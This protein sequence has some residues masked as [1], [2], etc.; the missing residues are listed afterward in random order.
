MPLKI[1]SIRRAFST[2]MATTVVVIALSASALG[3][4]LLSP[5]GSEFASVSDSGITGNGDSD[6]SSISD[7]GRFV[8]FTS[9]ATNFAGFPGKSTQIYRRDR[10][11]HT[12]SLVSS[13]QTGAFGNDASSTGHISGDGR[14]AFFVSQAT[15][16]VV[17]PDLNGTGEDIYRK[18]LASGAIERV[19]LT[20]TGVQPA[21][22]SVTSYQIG[23]SDNGQLV[24]FTSPAALVSADTN[25]F[26]DVYIRDIAAGTTELI[27]VEA[28]GD[29]ANDDS[30]GPAVSGDGQRIAFTS[31]ATGLDDTEDVQPSDPSQI[32][33]RDRSTG[34]TDL[35]SELGEVGDGD[36]GD[37]DI[38]Q[39]GK[40]IAYWSGAENLISGGSAGSAIDVY[41]ADISSG[42]NVRVTDPIFGAPDLN[43]KS[44]S[45]SLSGDGSV[46]SF[47][48]D[49]DN[50]IEGDPNGSTYDCFAMDLTNAYRVRLQSFGANW[51]SICDVD[52]ADNA[53]DTAYRSQDLNPAG[54]PGLQVIVSPLK[55]ISKDDEKKVEDSPTEDGTVA[56]ESSVAAATSE[57]ATVTVT[58][59]STPASRPLFKGWFGYI[60][61][62]WQ[63]P[64]AS[65]AKAGRRKVGKK[66]YMKVLPTEAA[67]L[68]S[69]KIRIKG[70][71]VAKASNLELK[72]G[73]RNV[74]ALK[75]TAYGRK[76]LNGKRYG[77]KMKSSVSTTS[78]A[79][80]DGAPY[81]GTRSV[82]ISRPTMARK[83]SS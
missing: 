67:K 46:I 75:T 71:L 45:P 64:K 30:Y 22:K 69:L 47:S 60:K 42:G 15:D 77:L 50:L 40:K 54:I 3:E 26:E 27:S 7:D 83:K 4:T 17:G 33:L 19:S 44:Y 58:T 68:T 36:S 11:N 14:Y 18:D 29:N 13:S 37:A 51:E 43:A 12:T 35:I 80:S 16:L 32:Y 10:A 25:G 57:T 82:S 66:I 48:S 74:I 20:E 9:V 81:S 8:V 49:A 53:L 63:S 76:L 2:L 23:S 72:A 79:T 52:V 73:K 78:A 21:T 41:V 5:G 6:Q 28:D 59:T 61:R 24:A 34:L 55:R 62:W 39:D 70:K 38:S 1:F 31:E 65:I 56:V